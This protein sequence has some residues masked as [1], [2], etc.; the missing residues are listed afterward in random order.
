MEEKEI[1][2]ASININGDLK[3]LG[4]FDTEEQ[5]SKAYQHK[6]KKQ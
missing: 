6:L 3:Y 2:K 4:V 5:A 1:W